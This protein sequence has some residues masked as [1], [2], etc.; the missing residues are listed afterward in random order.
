VY[1]DKNILTFRINILPP[2]SVSKSKP[3]RQH[4]LLLVRFILVC[5]VYSSN[6]KIEAVYYSETSVVFHR[7]TC[8]CITEDKTL[9]CDCTSFT[10]LV[11]RSVCCC[12]VVAGRLCSIISI[13]FHLC[14]D[15]GR[16]ELPCVRSLSPRT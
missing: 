2:F 13:D 3:S 16:R 10:G 4:A 6:L 7:S 1:S 14:T 9:Y 5:L 8:R 11:A 15:G 12:L